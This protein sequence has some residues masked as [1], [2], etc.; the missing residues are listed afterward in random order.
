M[1]SNDNNSALA[2]AISGVISSLVSMTVFY[3]LDTIKVRIQAS[4]VDE[5]QNEQQKSSMLKLCHELLKC[6]FGKKSKIS[7]LFRGIRTKSLHT[8]TSS[9]VYFYLYSFLQSTYRRHRLRK[10]GTKRAISASEQMILSAIAAMLNVI[11]TLPLD[12]MS[13][14]QQ[15]KTL[16]LNE[17]KD[18]AP[19]NKYMQN[20]IVSI[21]LFNSS[22]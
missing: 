16:N 18:K 13:A 14:R 20:F 12:V 4:G 15:T 19:Y 21:L 5:D 8:A 11:L 7:S 10:R 17:I 3:P 22:S 9:F 1:S 6:S 2:D